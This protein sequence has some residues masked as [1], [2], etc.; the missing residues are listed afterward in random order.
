LA[1]SL[2]ELLRRV[3]D[4]FFFFRFAGGRY[5]QFINKP[6]GSMFNSNVSLERIVSCR[7]FR[8]WGD[9]IPASRSDVKT[10]SKATNSVRYA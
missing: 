5:S 6:L 8:T 4:G 9:D 10:S 1:G 7:N 3:V 2:Y